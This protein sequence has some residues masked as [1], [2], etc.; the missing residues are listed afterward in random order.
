MANVKISDLPAS[1]TPL[2]GAELVPIVQSGVTKQTTV[3]DIANKGVASVSG[4]APITSSGGSTPTISMPPANAI[5]DGYL[6]AAY[7]SSFNSKQAELVSGSNIKTVNGNSLLGSGDLVITSGSGSVTSVSASLPLTV[8]NPTT[9]PSLSITVADSVHDG[10]LSSTDW[11]TFNSKQG[12][13]SLTTTGTSGASTLV[14]NTLNIPN[15]SA[16]AAIVGQTAWAGAF[17]D[18]TTQTA[19]AAN[20]AYAITLNTDDYVNGVSRGTPTSRIV[21]SNAGWYNLQWSGQF[22]NTNAGFQDVQ[23]WLRKNG[24]DVTGSTGYISIPNSHGGING[25]VITGWNYFINPSAGDYYEFYWTTTST[26]VSIKA[27]PAGTTPVTPTTASMIVTAAAL[28]QIGIGYYGLTSSTSIAI[29]TGSKVFTTNLADTQT[30]FTVGTRVRVASTVTPTNYMEGN[31]TAFSSTSLT[32]N[33]DAT[34]G[35]GTISSWTF[36]SI[37][38]GT[39]TSGSSILYG[40]GSGGFSNATVSTGLSFS[41]G[42]IKAVPRNTSSA[43][44]SSWNS[45][46]TD[47]LNITAQGTTITIG[48]DSDA[49]ATAQNGQKFIFRITANASITVSFTTG[50]S[51]AFRSIGGITLASVA[52]TSGQTYYVGC[53]YNSTDLRWDVV[54]SGIG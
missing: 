1:S 47:Q 30:A 9:T 12:A 20:T 40:N 21:F 41:S 35:S 49:G 6:T 17:Q 24:V 10:Y 23:I 54:A 11:S 51:Y 13:L 33:V 46:T 26:A 5:T 19:A 4:T 31:I 45:S 32:V 48:A 2:T 8:A 39:V 42:A 36:S 15:Y 43:T 34:G 18:N 37:G 16:G 14:G 22:E 3:Q 25:H 53:I 27:Y 7:W 38:S 44:Y 28:P 50:A 29:G 52:L